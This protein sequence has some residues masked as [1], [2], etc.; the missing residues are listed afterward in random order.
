MSRIVWVVCSSV[1]FGIVFIRI[2]GGVTVKVVKKFPILSDSIYV[3]IGWIGV[4]LLTETVFKTLQ[5]SHLNELQKFLVLLEIILLTLI[6]D[7]VPAVRR[8]VDPLLRSVCRPLLRAI[9]FPLAILF[10]PVR[11]VYALALGH[12]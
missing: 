7:A 5:I 12:D 8:L 11:K 2:L 10:W 6:Y 9:H 3:M 1:V 4:L